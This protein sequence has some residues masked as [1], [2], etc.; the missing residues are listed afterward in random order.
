MICHNP[1]TINNKYYLNS[2]KF[3]IKIPKINYCKN[4]KCRNNYFGAVITKNKVNRLMTNSRKRWVSL[5]KLMKVIIKN[6]KDKNKIGNLFAT[7]KS[8]QINYQSKKNLLVNLFAANKFVLAKI[9][10]H[11][12]TFPI[13]IN[14]RI[15]FYWVTDVISK[16]NWSTIYFVKDSHIWTSTLL[17]MI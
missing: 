13:P 17:K 11:L 16:H 14:L 5:M 15:F 6:K 4:S 9:Y 7:N 10:L 12:R 1:V 8:N 3:M 2:E